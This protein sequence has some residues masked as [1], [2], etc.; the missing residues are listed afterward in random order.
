MAVVGVLLL[1]APGREPPTP[2][3]DSPRGGS[4]MD[5]NGQPILLGPAVLTGAAIG[6]ASGW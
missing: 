1:A 2:P 5:E 6:G 3:V 4:R